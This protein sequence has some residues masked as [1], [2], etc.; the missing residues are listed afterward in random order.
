VGTSASDMVDYWAAEASVT[1]DLGSGL[2]TDSGGVDTLTSIEGAQGSFF[3]DTIFGNPGANL[4]AGAE[5]NDD[6]HGREGDDFLF[7][8]L[9]NDHL[10]GGDGNDSLHGGLNADVLDGGAGL[11]YARYDMSRDIGITVSLADPSLNTGE[12]VG[13]S[14]VDIEGLI[15][16]RGDDFGFGNDEGNWLRGLDGDDALNGAGG[17]DFLF[18]DLGDDSL[19]GG[20]G[21]DMLYG[22]YG[23]DALDGGSG[24]DYARYN[25]ANYGDVIV[26]LGDASLN[27]GAADGD[28][29]TAI[30]GLILGVGDDVGHGDGAGNYL[31]G[32]QGN[33]HLFGDGGNDLIHGGD[34]HDM[35]Y[36][37]VGADIH[38][39]GSGIDYARY[40][41]IAHDGFT[42]SL[43]DVSMG[44]G[45]AEGDTFI[46]I[47]G[48]ILG[49]GGDTGYGD[50]SFNYL[51]G[52]QGHDRLFGQ[53]GNDLVHG[54][55]GN[56]MLYG[57]WGA[58]VHN[59]GSGLD[60]ARYNDDAYDGFTVSLADFSLGTGVAAGD[61][62]ID[63][64]G[65][66]LGTRN[67][68]GYGDAARNYLFG[69]QGDDQLFGDGGDDRVNGGV[70]DDMLD[71]GSGDDLLSGGVGMDQLT[72]GGGADTFV[73]AAGFGAD[74]ISDFEG[75]FGFQDTIDLSTYAFS[76]FED[77]LAIASWDGADTTLNFSMSDSLVLE[78]FYLGNF[79][80]SDVLI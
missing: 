69:M 49:V 50:H 48:F 44:T 77:V 21:N 37:G 15:L 1:I 65:L 51:Y 67:D 17:N 53:G 45:V 31:Y 32:M 58:D 30:E 10:F 18:G 56:D 9:G 36:G 6:I 76:S 35:L 34:G 63:V 73:F 72:G 2:V 19:F 12:A 60:Y 33:D 13:D 55:A 22:G 4:L 64:E 14:Y 40:N 23:A 71:G 8:D 59:G 38:N 79:H 27:T 28:T 68:V 43:T 26:S 42:V 52:M 16:T 70:G 78:G 62:F 3:A 47:E 54:G 46:D 75:G 80:E 74:V 20:V 61:T 57:G 11:D 25:D 5:G 41:G 66:I 7:G 24:I 39:G 29:F